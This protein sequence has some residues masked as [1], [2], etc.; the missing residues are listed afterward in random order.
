MFESVLQQL[1]LANQNFEKTF[2]GES[3]QRQPVHVVYGGAHLFGAHT[4]VKLKKITEK[5]FLSHAPSPV[6]LYQAL[7]WA[8]DGL[9]DILYSRVVEKLR[10][11]AIEDYRI[12]FEDGFGVRSNDEEDTVAKT[13]AAELAA[14]LAEN[15]ISPFFGIRVKSLG[16]GL[17]QRSLRTLEL[18]MTTLAERLGKLPE[19]CIVTLPKVATLAH[20]QLFVQALNELEVRLRQPSGVL[21]LELMLEEPRNIVDGDGQSPLLSFRK[22]A[23]GRLFGV[24]FGT[25]DFTAACGVG[26]PFQQMQHPLCDFAKQLMQVALAGTE[27]FLADGATTVMPIAKHRDEDLSVAQ[28]SEND[29]IVH[30]AWRLH[31][32]NIQHS[33]RGGFYQGWDLH[34]GQIS[35]RYATVYRYFMIH[36]EGMAVRLKNFLQKAATATRVGDVF[37]DAATG[38][39]LLNFFRRGV[40]CGA[41]DAA[42][43]TKAGITMVDLA[44][45]SFAKIVASRSAV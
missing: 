32:D 31:S 3:A 36:A 43:L 45:G 44:S 10:R 5:L 2:P 38:R 25:Y 14:A 30:A 13:A 12:D 11:E 28:K 35:I 29:K 16:N 22:A 23:E 34:P 40:A 8:E 33:L 1:A 20:V 26:A 21:R 9:S 4:I 7:N 18:F 42:D 41:L 37:D 17:A 39:G 27:V 6:Q 24:H 15:T 19:R